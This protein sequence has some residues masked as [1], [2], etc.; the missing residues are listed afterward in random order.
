[1]EHNE[2]I[3]D[4]IDSLHEMSVKTQKC[5]ELLQEAFIHNKKRFLDECETITTDIHE[6]EKMLTGRL[7]EKSRIEA[8]ARNYIAVPGHLERIGDYIEDITKCQLKKINRDLIFSDRAMEETLQLLQKTK[9]VMKNTTD[10][11][12]SR[13][14]IISKYIIDSEDEIESDANKYATFHEDRMIEGLCTPE[15]SSIY[16]QILDALKGIAWHARQISEKLTK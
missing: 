13:N 15:A 16:L 12:L 1:M 5:I 14:E 4:E 6:T 11:I 8:A 2:K 10:L 3:K 7:L 9:D